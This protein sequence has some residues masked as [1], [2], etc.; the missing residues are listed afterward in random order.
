M[1]YNSHTNY[2]FLGFFG[3]FIVAGITLFWVMLC[4]LRSVHSL[5]APPLAATSCIDEKFKYLAERAIDNVDF[6][7]I[8][9]SVTWRNLDLTP[10]V[11]TRIASDPLNAAPCYLNFHQTV[12][13][14]E[15]LLD[16]LKHVKTVMTIVAPRDFEQCSQGD[17]AFFDKDQ[18]ASYVFGHGS[19]FLIY[20][21]NFRPLPF[22]KDVIAIA[23]RRSDVT[24][25]GG[26]VVMGPYGSGPIEG[27]IDEA[28]DWPP[29]A[30]LDK[31]C[32]RALTAFEQ[33]LKARGIEFIVVRFPTRPS[34]RPKGDPQREIEDN[35]D[36]QLRESLDAETTMLV[37]GR[38]LLDD[39]AA[40]FD[41][42]HFSWHGAQAFSVALANQ[43][44]SMMTSMTRQK[45]M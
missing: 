27:H 5:P 36:R 12:F 41:N 17:G 9:S 10:F 11:S 35:F 26:S 15:F 31:E 43:I 1:Q 6:L 40:Y 8:G 32:F 29:P 20:A 38:S 16:H 24:V 18:A 23:R 21:T 44:Q 45:E 30:V 2:R 33:F 22:F 39:R 28:I 37:P 13:L 7:A 3:L 19:P 25:P 14:G 34:L 4:G 42:V